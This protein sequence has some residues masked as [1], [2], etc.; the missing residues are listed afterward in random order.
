MTAWIAFAAICLLLVVEALAY[1]WKDHKA[2]RPEGRLTRKEVQAE[3]KAAG[4]DMEPAQKKLREM[5]KRYK[6]HA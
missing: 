5:L 3:L 2:C 1:L 4:I 6:N